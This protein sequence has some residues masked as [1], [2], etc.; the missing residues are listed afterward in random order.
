MCLDG[1]LWENVPGLSDLADRV[2]TRIAAGVSGEEAAKRVFTDRF[3]QGI[4]ARR[5]LDDPVSPDDSGHY[6]RYKP[7]IVQ[8]FDACDGNLSATERDLRAR[9]I[10]CTRR[11]LGVYLDRWGVRKLQPR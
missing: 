5:H 7:Q 6:E 8:A 11:W 2:A 4:V 10:M 9:G 1:F 3:G